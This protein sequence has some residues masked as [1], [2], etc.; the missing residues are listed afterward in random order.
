MSTPPAG[1]LLMPGATVSTVTV[2]VAAG[3]AWPLPT[4]RA[5]MV[6]GPSPNRWAGWS[7]A[8]SFSLS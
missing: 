2:R 1:A 4:T 6:F 8:R 5:T 3:L 7:P